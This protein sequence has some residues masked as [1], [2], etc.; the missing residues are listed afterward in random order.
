MENRG[1]DETLAESV[2]NAA[3]L[4]VDDKTVQSLGQLLSDRNVPMPQRFRSIF[5]LKNIG[6]QRAVDALVQG[7]GDKSALLKHEIAF[8]LGQMGNPHAVPTLNKVLSNTKEHPM[9]RHEAGEALGA[10]AQPESVDILTQFS[11]DSMPEVAETCQIALDRIKW[12]QQHSTD[13]TSPFASVDPAPPLP[14]STPTPQ[15]K[16]QLLDT[17]LSLFDRYRALFTLRDKADTEAV[18]ALCE[19]L[20]DKSALFRHEIAYVLGQL[21]NPAA[22]NALK[23]VLKNEHEN[24]MVRHEAA[25][26]LGAIA[27]NECIPLLSDHLS[28]FE[29][30]VKESCE[31]ALDIHS[32][33]TSDEFQYANGLNLTNNE[34]KS[35]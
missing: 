14:L 34:N 19:G 30:V 32:Y 12:F 31:V 4:A 24:G 8:V 13:K 1:N 15:L 28:D 3:G 26:A 2:H 20:K 21:Q 17:S 22:I 27:T 18:E 25:E 11:N 6:G 33:F 10:I 5:T 23:E 29:D 7:L 9:V 35:Q 16:A